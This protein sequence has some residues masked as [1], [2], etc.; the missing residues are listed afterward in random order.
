[1]KVKQQKRSNNTV[2][3]A[4]RSSE[5]MYDDKKDSYVH[6]KDNHLAEVIRS[7]LIQDFNL[8]DHLQ[9][10]VINDPK[11]N[12]GDIKDPRI[13][14]QLMVEDPLQ[15]VRFDFNPVRL[16]SDILKQRKINRLQNRY[17]KYPPLNM[18]AHWILQS[19]IFKNLILYLII[20][21]T[22]VFALEADVSDKSH[23][24]FS[25]MKTILQVIDWSIFSFLLSEVILRWLDDFPKFWTNRWNI[26]DLFVLLLSIVPDII[27]RAQVTIGINIFFLKVFR[28]LRIF[29]YL[30]KMERCHQVRLILLAI[31]K[32]FK[33]MT[34]ILVLVLLF[35]YVFAVGGVKLFI[36]YT[37]SDDS[38]LMYREAFSGIMNALQTLFQLFTLDHWYALLN[39]VWRVKEVDA[40]STGV[41]IIVW[42]LIGSFIFRNIMVGIMV[43]NFQSIRAELSVQIQQMEILKKA[44]YFKVQLIQREIQ[45][46]SD[47]SATEQES[48]PP[49]TSPHLTDNS[50]M[51]SNTKWESQAYKNIQLLKSHR[52][53]EKVTWPRDSLFRYYELLEQLQYNLEERNKLQD[54]AAQCLLNMHDV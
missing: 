24:K 15:L 49:G 2:K 28:T 11:Y 52:G 17:V 10:L 47:V 3:T 7:K 23:P 13:L 5:Q 37:K 26:F 29:R 25:A 4:I 19:Y 6:S 31:S 16:T 9:G 53:S 50:H 27:F 14:N 41:Y 43:S 40:F 21:N 51:K 35:A 34:F 42:I 12:M 39:D 44:D 33:A 38:T 22:I 30:K 45:G 48:I 18:C 46:D 8:L 32:A 36:S 20:I 54:L 1:M